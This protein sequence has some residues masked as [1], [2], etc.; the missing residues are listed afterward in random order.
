M[1]SQKPHRATNA[2]KV[3]VIPNIPHGNPSQIDG[4]ILRLQGLVAAYHRNLQQMKIDHQRLVLKKAFRRTQAQLRLA[5]RQRRSLE[6][7]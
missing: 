6:A 5:R 2:V 7:V 3:R 4:E 1:A